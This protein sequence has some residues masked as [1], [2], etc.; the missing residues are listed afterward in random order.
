MRVDGYKKVELFLI[1]SELMSP[2]AFL[3]MKNL[4][5]FINKILKDDSSFFDKIQIQKI[6]ICTRK[7]L[8]Q[9]DI[10]KIYV[11]FDLNLSMDLESAVDRKDCCLFFADEKEAKLACEFLTEDTEEEGT[12]FAIKTYLA[13]AS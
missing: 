5:D 7:N 8:T 11:V 9:A 2:R 6:E 3:N 12:D 1:Q 10:K 13:T 4:M